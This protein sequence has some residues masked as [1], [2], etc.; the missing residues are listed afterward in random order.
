MS[1]KS[2]WR[3]W[4]V[5]VHDILEVG[6][7]DPIGRVF[8][9][10]LVTLILAN[11]VAFAAEA[12]AEVIFVTVRTSIHLLGEPWYQSQLTRQ[13][14]EARS[15]LDDAERIAEEQGVPYESEILEGDPAPMI[16]A[17]AKL[18]QADLVVVG[19]R[20]HSALASAVIGSVSRS[21][22]SRSR[23]PVM[24]VCDHTA[25]RRSVGAR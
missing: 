24:V 12:G 22:L 18:R 6:D 1:L 19:S 11:G 3:D 25:D 8:N 9:V 5:K 17:V 23:V 13:L 20:G 16:A 2:V 21:L 15:A 4:R 7:G 14:G 10:F